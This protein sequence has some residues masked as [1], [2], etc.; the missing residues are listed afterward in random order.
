MTVLTL[1]VPPELDRTIRLV[2][3]KRGT[4][5]SAVVRA[6]IERYVEE[7]VSVVAEPSTLDLVRA[8]AGSVRGPADLA[9]DPAHLEGYGQ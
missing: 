2:A 1:K 9:V 3:R 5:R 7:D 4:S 6:A 8:F